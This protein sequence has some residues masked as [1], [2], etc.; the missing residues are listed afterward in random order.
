M[1]NQ[2]GNGLIIGILIGLVVAGGLFAAFYLGMQKSQS[3][4]PQ[5]T[6]QPTSQPVVVSSAPSL[7]DPLGDFPIYPGSVK[8]E[9]EMNTT[10]SCSGDVQPGAT[11]NTKY[12]KYTAQD[13]FKNVYNFYH[14]VQSG[15]DCSKS[16]GAGSV[17]DPSL[18]I[19]GDTKSTTLQIGVPK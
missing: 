18:Q 10:D 15:W 11:C 1:A 7:P 16:G 13:S 2:S 14:K 8:S 5:S 3:A 19:S 4:T 12:F 9:S 6:L 17:G